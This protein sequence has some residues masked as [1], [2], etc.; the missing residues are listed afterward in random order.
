ML[1]SNAR[2][3]L[4]DVVAESTWQQ[5]IEEGRQPDNAKG[6]GLLLTTVVAARR[7]GYGRRSQPPMQC[8]P[9]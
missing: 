6:D 7:F 2:I 1:K 3:C 5:A 8:I 9:Q 4:V